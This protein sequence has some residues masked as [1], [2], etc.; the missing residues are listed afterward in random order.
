MAKGIKLRQ[1]VIAKF[2]P[3]GQIVATYQAYIT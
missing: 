3:K 1:F 2:I